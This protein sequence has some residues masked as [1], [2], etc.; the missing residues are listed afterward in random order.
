MEF[1]R[2]LYS[3]E[4]DSHPLFPIIGQF[5]SLQMEEKA[6]LS[7]GVEDHEV[8]HAMFDIGAHEA[9]RPDGFHAHV[10]QAD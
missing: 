10:H 5:R 6:R 2:H 3:K 1:Y 7:S 8:K 9:P 4:S